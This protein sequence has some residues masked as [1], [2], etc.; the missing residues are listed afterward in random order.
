MPKDFYIK[1]MQELSAKGG[2]RQS[3]LWCKGFSHSGSLSI[4][5][6]LPK[7]LLC[8]YSPTRNNETNLSN[9]SWFLSS[10]EIKI[11]P[12]N[13]TIRRQEKV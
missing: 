4:S 3:V 12:Y 9:R 10:A 7:G 2:F 11:Y 1:D 6:K 13:L 5:F 8:H